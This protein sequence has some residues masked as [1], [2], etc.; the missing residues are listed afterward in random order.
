MQPSIIERNSRHPR[1][2]AAHVSQ[3]SYPLPRSAKIISSYAER[4]VAPAVE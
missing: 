3:V 1:F 2:S 4:S